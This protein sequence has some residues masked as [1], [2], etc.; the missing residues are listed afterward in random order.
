ML[1][2]IRAL[3]HSLLTFFTL[4]KIR[5]RNLWVFTHL[6]DSLP[7][8][9]GKNL[10]ELQETPKDLGRCFLFLHRLTN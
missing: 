1:L 9:P 4:F 3:H 5:F 10:C 7:R 2:P 8:I 6:L